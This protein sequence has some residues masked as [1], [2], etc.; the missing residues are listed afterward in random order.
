MRIIIKQKLE[1]Q[2]TMRVQEQKEYILQKSQNLRNEKQKFIKLLRDIK[3]AVCNKKKE[4]GQ[5]KLTGVLD[6]IQTKIDELYQLKIE[7]KAKQD[8]EMVK[9]DLQQSYNISTEHY[10]KQVELLQNQVQELKKSSQDTSATLTKYKDQ[11]ENLAVNLHKIRQEYYK[12]LNEIMQLNQKNE[13][14]QQ[15]LGLK[16]VRLANTEESKDIY[17]KQVK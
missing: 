10:Q 11:N 7:N 12:N 13:K 5:E 1:Q 8:P 17:M 2:S 6:H 3:N 16:N 15:E 9:V 4:E 14:Q